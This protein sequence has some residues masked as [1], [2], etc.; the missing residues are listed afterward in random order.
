MRNLL[1]AIVLLTS[2]ISCQ[3]FTQNLTQGLEEEKSYT[4]HAMETYRKNPKIFQEDKGVLETWSRSDYVALAVAQHSK[5]RHWAETSDKLDFLDSKVQR[6]TTGRPFCAIHEDDR[7]LVLSIRSAA[8]STCSPDL[9]NG[10]DLSRINSGDMEFS[11]RT[12]FWIYVL[13]PGW[14]NSKSDRQSG[15]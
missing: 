13:M 12:D 9:L 2:M 8:V 15:K 10:V 6:D 5:S 7:I 4:R 3:K 11:G 1:I 14:D